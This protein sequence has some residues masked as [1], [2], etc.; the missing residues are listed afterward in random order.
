MVTLRPAA[1]LLALLVPFPAAAALPRLVSFLELAAYHYDGLAR[2]D[3]FGSSFRGKEEAAQREPF[4]FW[5]S[6]AL[7]CILSRSDAKLVDCRDTSTG[8]VVQRKRPPLVRLPVKSLTLEAA[9][10]A[11]NGGITNGATNRVAKLRCSRSPLLDREY[12]YLPGPD[13]RLAVLVLEEDDVRQD[14]AALDAQCPSSGDV[15]WR[16]LVAVP[17][18]PAP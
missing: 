12:R 14:C 3:G 11:Q 18:C 5:S 1:L 10:L 7:L 15:S 13:G 17:V 2:P 16:V 6:D 8:K 4:I 9:T